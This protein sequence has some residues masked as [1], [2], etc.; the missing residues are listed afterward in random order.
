MPVVSTTL[1]YWGVVSLARDTPADMA[2]ATDVRSPT[3]PLEC[4]VGCRHLAL[5]HS[6]TAVKQCPAATQ[7]GRLWSPAWCLASKLGVRAWTSRRHAQ[8]QERA[9]SWLAPH[10]PRQFGSWQVS[11]SN[12]HRQLTG[13]HRALAAIQELLLSM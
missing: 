11:A 7:R 4:A 9:L 10:E 1:L 8:M 12:R 6:W 5:P 2:W 3:S 13:E